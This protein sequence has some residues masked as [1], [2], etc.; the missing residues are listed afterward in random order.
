M[1]IRDRWCSP[2][3]Y[4]VNLT[5][6]GVKAE[7]TAAQRSG[8]LRFT[9]PEADDAFIPVS[10]THLITAVTEAHPGFV[11]KASKQY[12]LGGKL[13]CGTAHPTLWSALVSDKFRSR[14][15]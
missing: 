9:Y 1:C 5:D 6:Y 14:C 13:E 11:D 15:V 10:Y 2:A 12:N 4:G 7:M 3:Y 8:I